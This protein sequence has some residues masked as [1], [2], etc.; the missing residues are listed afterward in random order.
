[1]MPP[2]ALSRR[3]VLTAT[4]L[5]LV[6]APRAFA[7]S[8]VRLPLRVLYARVED[9]GFA[10][11]THKETLAWSQFSLRLGGLVSRLEPMPAM[12]R[13]LPGPSP[14]DT[15]AAC[16]LMARKAAA[17]LGLDGAI[18]YATDPLKPRKPH[19]SVLHNLRPSTWFDHQAYGEAHVLGL[20][21]GAPLISVASD[22]PKPSLS[23]FDRGKSEDAALDRLLAAL[24]D[25]LRTLRAEAYPYEQSI[26]D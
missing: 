1:M 18:L 10:R 15:G 12:S 19:K 20:D 17:D 13:L 26:A 6:A 22:G 16:V 21:S 24:E 7:A 9:G 3:A 14:A 23:P 25:R 11:L 2:V 5:A 8:P 4:A